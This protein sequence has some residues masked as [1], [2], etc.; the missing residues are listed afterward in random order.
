ML[1]PCL[2]SSIMMCL[3]S[4]AISGMSC[5]AWRSDAEASAKAP[6][7]LEPGA[8]VAGCGRFSSGVG[9]AEASSG[10]I[11]CGVLQLRPRRQAV[12]LDDAGIAD[13]CSA[14]RRRRASSRRRS[15]ASAGPGSRT[16]PASRRTR[17]AGPSGRRRSR[18]SRDRRRRGRRLS[19]SSPCARSAAVRAA[20]RPAPAPPRPRR[21]GG[22]SRADRRAASR[23][24]ASGSW[25]R[26]SSARRR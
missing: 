24:P 14:R 26:G 2:V 20:V 1:R 22:A 11:L 7:L 21:R 5:S 4:S 18:T 17:P 15:A 3:E 25:R 13:R 6:S 9:V 23:A 16:R 8:E 12:D 10:L 19:F